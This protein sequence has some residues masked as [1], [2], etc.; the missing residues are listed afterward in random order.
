M[1]YI[2]LYLSITILTIV[3]IPSFASTPGDG[4]N[5]Y[6]WTKNGSKT[7]YSLDNLDRLTF[8]DNTM[9]V[10][11]SNG[12]TSYPYSNI[13]LVT[14]KDGIRPTTGIEQLTTP[15]TD[16]T[17]KYDK[18]A[19]MLLVSS[20]KTLTGIMVCDLQGRTVIREKESSGNTQLSLSG[21]PK[22]IYLIKVTGNGFGKSV[23]II[24]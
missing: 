5:L 16:V 22:G 9:S 19:Q 21:L 2:L 7:V 14:F 17:I 12:K 11:K 15:D 18:E 24:K 20:E 8:E 23:K 13:G 4:D 1:K 6:V 10:W 3:S